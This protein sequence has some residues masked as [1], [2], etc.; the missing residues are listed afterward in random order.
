MS[1]LMD[2]MVCLSLDR[3]SAV[4]AGPVVLSGNVRGVKRQLTLTSLVLLD[5]GELPGPKP[6]PVCQN[7]TAR[8]AQKQRK[9]TF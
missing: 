6:C 7:G 1:P 4:A 9:M 2:G 3:G 5:V 8:L